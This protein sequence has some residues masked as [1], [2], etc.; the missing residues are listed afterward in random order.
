MESFTD[1]QVKF[2]GECE[3][4]F[5]N[6]YTEQDKAFMQV[7]NATPINPPAIHPWYSSRDMRGEDGG[8]NRRRDWPRNNKDR[9]NWSDEKNQNR[10]SNKNV[11]RKNN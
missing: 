11:D 10:W 5:L 4:E 1:E 7:K 6:R 2:L 3:K 8:R 9:T